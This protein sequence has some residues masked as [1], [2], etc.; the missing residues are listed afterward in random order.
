MMGDKKVFISYSRKDS[1]WLE[2]LQTHLK[3]LERDGTID[4][5]HDRRIKEGS[6]WTDEV[7]VATDTADVAI[8]LISASFFASDFITKKEL[9]AL[10]TGNKE[11]EMLILLIFVR[12]CSLEHTKEL[13]RFQAFNSPENPLIAMSQGEQDKL[14][15]KVV[16]RVREAVLPETGDR[17]LKDFKKDTV[18]SRTRSETPIVPASF[19]DNSAVLPKRK[20]LW[21]RKHF[22]WAVLIG[23]AL[24]LVIAGILARKGLWVNA[25]DGPEKERIVYIIGGGTVNKYLKDSGFFKALEDQ[26]IS[27]RAMQ[28]PTDTLAAA[29]LPHVFE[30]VKEVTILV[31]ASR[32]LQINLPSNGKPLGIFAAY[33]GPDP[34]EMLFVAGE[35]GP[36][37]VVLYNVFNDI[38]KNGSIKQ[39][40]FANLCIMKKWREV[41]GNDKYDVY[42]G[43]EGSGTRTVWNKRLD[44]CVPGNLN[45]WDMRDIDGMIKATN[46][47]IYLGS[48]AL[49]HSRLEK[50]DAH[51]RHYE[52]LEMIDGTKIARRGLYLYGFVETKESVQHGEASGYD[53][54]KSVVRILKLIYE[55]E[56]YL[57]EKSPEDSKCRER[58]IEYFNLNSKLESES[59]WVK[60]DSGKGGI[61]EA[62]CTDLGQPED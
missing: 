41:K 25:S 44:R 61:F 29:L 17:A 45:V 23:L 56:L 12:E 5:W 39:L 53:L 3:P 54:P 42:V 28:T 36:K 33:L 2:S 47:R 35:K 21:Q 8:L 46:P 10:L 20:I 24:G 15:K 14:F 27:Y 16:E 6:I 4:L 40:D 13:Q 57:F 52:L 55:S 31:M 11:R 18:S 19:P 59:G 49:F 32:K 22:V 43:S 26:H 38:L 48:E 62:P 9:P 34:L 51:E 60:I 50:L 58:Q 30:D 37:D 1:S 7:A